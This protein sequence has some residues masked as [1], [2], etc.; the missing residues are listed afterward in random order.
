MT[1]A[2][3]KT[4]MGVPLTDAADAATVRKKKRKRARKERQKLI[5]AL[6]AEPSRDDAM[7]YRVPGSFESRQR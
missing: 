1:E 7:N 4:L 2:K 3:R 6:N 5:A